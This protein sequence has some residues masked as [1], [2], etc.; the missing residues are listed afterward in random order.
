MYLASL[1]HGPTKELID[2]GIQTVI[3][4]YVRIAMFVY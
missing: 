2:N 3:P 4:L 1:S